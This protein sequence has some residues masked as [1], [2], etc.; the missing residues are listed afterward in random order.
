MFQIQ[1]FLN[2]FFV[3]MPVMTTKNN[4]DFASFYKICNNGVD[5]SQNNENAIWSNRR[6]IDPL[7]LIL[8]NILHSGNLSA[9]AT[10]MGLLIKEIKEIESREKGQKKGVYMFIGK[11]ILI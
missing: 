8:Y 4:Y 3:E 7:L 1:R 11:N 10:E 5:Y 2:F 6:S 9:D